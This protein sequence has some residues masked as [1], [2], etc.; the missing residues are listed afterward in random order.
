MI[1]IKRRDLL[2]GLGVAGAGIALA[3]GIVKA[4]SKK[5]LKILVLGGTGF[6]GP[7]IVREALAR[8]HEVT[9]F[10]R[11]RSNTDLFPDVEKLVGDRYGG[12]DAEKAASHVAMSRFKLV[13]R[14]YQLPLIVTHFWDSQ[15]V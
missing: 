1:N 13:Q 4:Q 11:G 6:I 14:L 7:H 3:P 8:G 5:V 9:L 15:G 2:L 10:N 12:L